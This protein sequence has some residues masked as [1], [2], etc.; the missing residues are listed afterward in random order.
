MLVVYKLRSGWQISFVGSV[1]QYGLP[2][3]SPLRSL[4]MGGELRQGDDR[5]G[6]SEPTG[7]DGDIH[8]AD[9]YFSGRQASLPQWTPIHVL[10]GRLW[11]L[12][13][14]PKFGFD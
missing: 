1:S 6:D 10:F 9:N 2:L 7:Y 5:W 14:G 13:R 8:Q 4:R 12:A 11:R 3:R